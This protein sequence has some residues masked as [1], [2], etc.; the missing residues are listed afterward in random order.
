MVPSVVRMAG[1]LKAM[2]IHMYEYEY[3]C[4]VMVVTKK[5]VMTIMVGKRQE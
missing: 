3:V 4:T 2:V 1:Y 5:I